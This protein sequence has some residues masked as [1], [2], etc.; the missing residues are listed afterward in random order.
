M[1]KDEET[2]TQEKKFGKLT[3]TPSTP[4]MSTV[5]SRWEGDFERYHMNEII[6]IVDGECV[7]TINGCTYIATPQNLVLVPKHSSFSHRLT[8]KKKLTYFSVKL[9]AELFGQSLFEYLEL[10]ADNHVVAVPDGNKVYS[11][12]ESCVSNCTDFYAY[13]LNLC[14]QLSQIL[15]IYVEQRLSDRKK[16]PEDI[17][18]HFEPVID[19]MKRN[20]DKNIAIDELAK[21]VHMPASTFNRKFLHAFG[22]S[23]IRY[24]DNLRIQ[25][26]VELITHSDWPISKI[27]HAIGI[28]NKY[29]FAKFF[30]KHMNVSPY[31][32]LDIFRHDLNE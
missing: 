8:S 21:I 25:K 32:Y 5:C 19:Y 3:I 9:D 7:L 13:R 27:S 22:I 24:Y 29:Y 12:I 1:Y 10:T 20:L 26:V 28:D 30:M 4:A 18:D 16:M 11:I 17:D 2:N 6:Y 23:P 31:E 15:S 14:S